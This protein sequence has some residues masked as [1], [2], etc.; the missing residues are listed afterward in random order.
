MSSTLLSSR[1]NTGKQRSKFQKK[2]QRWS[3][4]LQARPRRR[5]RITPVCVLFSIVYR[6]GTDGLRGG[7][8]GGINISKLLDWRDTE[9][10]KRKGV[11][12]PNPL[13]TTASQAR[14]R[15]TGASPLAF[16]NNLHRVRLPTIIGSGD[17]IRPRRRRPIKRLARTRCADEVAIGKP[18]DFL[19]ARSGTGP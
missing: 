7:G 4:T 6:S 9:R 5:G 13:L 19:G 15:S 3:A 18:I 14:Q 12:E 16:N 17:G 10:R 1:G 11:T 8:T 2:C